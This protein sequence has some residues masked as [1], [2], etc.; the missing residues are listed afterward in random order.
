MVPGGG[1][2]GRRGLALALATPKVLGT[3]KMGFSCWLG[4]PKKRGAHAA[5][6]PA[7]PAGGGSRGQQISAQ[8]Q[9]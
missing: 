8:N 1:W 5:S 9:G 6:C 7:A 2:K 4:S 3:P